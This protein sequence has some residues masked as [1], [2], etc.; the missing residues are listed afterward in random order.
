MYLWR[1]FSLSG[2]IELALVSIRRW[3]KRRT[4]VAPRGE[5][6]AQLESVRAGDPHRRLGRGRRRIVAHAAVQASSDVID[7]EPEPEPIVFANRRYVASA[8]P[9]T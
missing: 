7:P 2:G 4:A 3:V 8:C 1:S 9:T 6:L 5:Y